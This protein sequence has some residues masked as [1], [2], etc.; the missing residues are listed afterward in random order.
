MT[1]YLDKPS[2]PQEALEHAGVKGMRWGVRKR[3]ESGDGFLI[4]PPVARPRSSLGIR[5]TVA[6]AATVVSV[7][8]I[9]ATAAATVLG[10][11][12]TRTILEIYNKETSEGY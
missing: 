2:T 6:T 9:G 1:L 4:G 11:I 7:G 8:A 12:G 5:K 10:T 3:Q